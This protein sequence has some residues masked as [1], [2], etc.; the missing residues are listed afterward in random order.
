MKVMTQMHSNFSLI[1]IVP[2][3]DASQKNLNR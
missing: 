2:L 1:K 3:K